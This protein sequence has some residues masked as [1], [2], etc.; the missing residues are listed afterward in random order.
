MPLE[1]REGPRGSP[2]ANRTKL[3]WVAFSHVPAHSHTIQVCRISVDSGVDAGVEDSLSIS[4][5]FEK[6]FNDEAIPVPKRKNEIRSLED[7]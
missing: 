4:Q 7:G 5:H 3:G 2:T 1:C 6:W